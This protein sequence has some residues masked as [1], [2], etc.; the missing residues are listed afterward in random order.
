MVI[1]N[2]EQERLS[3]LEGAYEQVSRRLDDLYLTVNTLRTEMN[4]RFDELNSRI[5]VLIVV[6]V[7]GWM[8]IIAALIAAFIALY[9]K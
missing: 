7:G 5:N 9:L 4:S 2:I 6:M 8:T 1:S 3:R